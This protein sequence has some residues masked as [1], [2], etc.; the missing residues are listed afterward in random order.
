M[1]HLT[2]N[3]LFLQSANEA[4]LP[5]Y[6]LHQSVLIYVGYFVVQSSIP[7]ALKWLVIASTSFAIIIGLIAI[8]QRVNVLRFLFGMKPLPRSAQPAPAVTPLPQTSE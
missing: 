8:I 1:K 2:R 4:V 6:V 3:T 7:D 5:F